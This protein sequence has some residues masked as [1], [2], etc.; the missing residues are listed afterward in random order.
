MHESV[1]IGDELPDHFILDLDGTLVQGM[2]VL[3]G[4]PDVLRLLGSRYVIVSNN[5]TH[6]CAELSA[7]LRRNGLDVPADK[8][9]LAGPMAVDMVARDHAGARTLLLGSD[10]IKRQAR[11]AGLRLVDDG[12][13]IVLLARDTGFTYDKL[14]RAA[15]EV[16]RG[17]HLVVT[18]PDLSH[19][20]RGG[21]VVPET[22]SL[23]QALIACARPETVQLI[24][25]P[26]PWLF[27]EAMR[28][29]DATADTCLMVGDN[30]DTDAAGARKLGIPCLLLV[31]GNGTGAPGVAA[32]AQRLRGE[33]L[34]RAG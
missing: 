26:E 10:S 9:V 2:D 33:A 31:G 30:P 5:S 24:G 34:Q 16:R 3:D 14:V 15:N 1:S 22:G 27:E 6:S 17:A 20:G 8:L 18:N 19:P 29:L 12:A 21:A 7:D 4:A 23:L 13:D 32:L 11:A 28:R 25:K